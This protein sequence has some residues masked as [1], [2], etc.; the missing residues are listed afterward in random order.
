MKLRV[1]PEAI[2]DTATNEPVTK[3]VGFEEGTLLEAVECNDH[4]RIT[5]VFGTAPPVNHQDNRGN[6][7]ATAWRHAMEQKR[8]R[9]NDRGPMW[10]NRA[11][12]LERTG[13]LD[14]SEPAS[15]RNQV[16]LVRQN[17]R[18]VIEEGRAYN[19]LA[20]EFDLPLLDWVVP[21]AEDDDRIGVHVKPEDKPAG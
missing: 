9:L 18:K 16:G 5:G 20:E 2:I 17:A 21:P 8:R 3:T 19:A 7:M 11:R 14:D 13:T 1:T 6:R 4:L 15:Y 10:V 12:M